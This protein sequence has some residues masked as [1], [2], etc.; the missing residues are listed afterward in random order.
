LAR[1]AHR[2]A[3]LGITRRHR[4]R[5]KNVPVRRDQAARVVHLVAVVRVEVVDAADMVDSAG[6][7]AVVARLAR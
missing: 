7:A 1:G 6:S 3:S 5:A 2:L 4:R